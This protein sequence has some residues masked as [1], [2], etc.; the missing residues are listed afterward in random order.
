MK[1]S[2]VEEIGRETRKPREAASRGCAGQRDTGFPESGFDRALLVTVLGEVPDR[3]TAVKEVFE[4]LRPGGLLAVTEV[5]F[6]PHFLRRTIARLAEAVGFRPKAVHGNCL[7][8][9]MI[10]ERPADEPRH[11]PA[12]SGNPNA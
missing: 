8:Y 12:T 7:A 6:D 4:A 3:H 9:T 1:E 5:I 2:N 11:S 10:F